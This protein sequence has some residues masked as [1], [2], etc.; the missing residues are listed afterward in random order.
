MSGF[1][2]AR[3]VHLTSVHRPDDVRIFRKECRTLAAAGYEVVLVASGA[4]GSTVDGVRFHPIKRSSSRA[5]RLVLGWGRILAA[6]LSERGAL[7]HLH[8]PELLPVGL[9]LRLM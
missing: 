4:G 3:V 1:R 6:A 5:A 7:Y 9:M 2:G 8:D